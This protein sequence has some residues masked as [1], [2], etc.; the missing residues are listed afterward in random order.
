MPRMHAAEKT[1]VIR[2]VARRSRGG[3]QTGMIHARGAPELKAQAEGILAEIGL[4]SRDAIRLF[5]KQ[6]PL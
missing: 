6:V 1:P 3:A 5:D 4:R 2:K